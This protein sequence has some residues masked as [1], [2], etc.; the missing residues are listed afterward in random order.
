MYYYLLVFIAITLF[1]ASFFT[2]GRYQQRVGASFTSSMVLSAGVGLFGCIGLLCFS[3]FRLSATPFTVLMALLFAVS[4]LC[5]S[6]CTVFSLERASLS[7]FSAFS[8]IGGMILPSVVGMIFFGE[9]LTLCKGICY[10]LTVIGLSLTIKRDSGKKAF[11]SYVGVFFFNGSC[12]AISTVFS[13]ADFEKAGS[14][15][16][17]ILSAAFRFVLAVIVLPAAVYLARKKAASAG[18]EA[19]PSNVLRRYISPAVIILLALGGILNTVGNYL[20]PIAMIDGGLDGSVVYPMITGGVMII[21]TALGFL[22]K[23]KPTLREILAVAVCTLGLL[24]LV[25]PPLVSA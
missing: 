1:G 8:M 18:T 2:N 24:V 12:A 21:S 16:Y 11:L 9:K 4:G 19:P 6:L 17:S 5:L 25:I 13:K 10:V 3:G 22:N 7:L 23:R 20:L 15:D 14:S